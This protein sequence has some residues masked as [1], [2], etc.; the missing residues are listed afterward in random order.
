[1]GQALVEKRDLS[2]LP[3]TT[4]YRL[5]QLPK[6]KCLRRTEG[7]IMPHLHF[8]QREFMINNPDILA[9]IC[10]KVSTSGNKISCRM[11]GWNPHTSLRE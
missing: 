3:E 10:Y 8:L 9:Y 11:L 1:M 4:I 5:E 6:E 7:T 2:G